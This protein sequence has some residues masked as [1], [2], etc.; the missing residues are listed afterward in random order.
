MMG[1]DLELNARGW[2][3]REAAKGVSA[4]L[5]LAKESLFSRVCLNFGPWVPGTKTL[6]VEPS[7]LGMLEHVPWRHTLQLL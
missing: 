7:V 4:Y 1:S 5:K 2:S 3:K 6:G